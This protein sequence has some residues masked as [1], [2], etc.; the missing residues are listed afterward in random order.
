MMTREKMIARMSGHLLCNVLPE[1]YTGWE[2][3]K[4]VNFIDENKWEV[5]EWRTA[6]EVLEHIAD[7]ADDVLSILSER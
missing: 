1:D 3:E 4:L 6:E 2:Y 5:L 7:L